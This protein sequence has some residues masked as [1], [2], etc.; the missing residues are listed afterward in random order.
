LAG[1][2][3]NLEDGSV[4]VLI[5]FEDQVNSILSSIVVPPHNT[6]VNLDPDIVTFVKEHIRLDYNLESYLT[7]TYHRNLN[8]DDWDDAPIDMGE[9]VTYHEGETELDIEYNQIKPH[10]C[11]YADWMHDLG[12]RRDQQWD[13]ATHNE[14]RSIEAKAYVTKVVLI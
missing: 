9:D 14:E 11:A 10:L 13:R 6:D 7:T 1:S 5:P 12:C 8:D 3:K 2:N 4:Y